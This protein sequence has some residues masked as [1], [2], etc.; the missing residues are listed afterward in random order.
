M[1]S[2]QKRASAMRMR[3]KKLTRIIIIATIL[4]HSSIK[5]NTAVMAKKGEN[6]IASE[7]LNIGS[8]KLSVNIIICQ[9]KF[10]LLMY[11]GGKWYLFW[12]R[13]IVYYYVHAGIIAVT[14]AEIQWLSEYTHAPS[15]ES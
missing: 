10:M 3:T 13:G 5:I 12:N 1:E 14:Y 6:A 15:L 11:W 2:T 4:L 8:L 7:V 9:V